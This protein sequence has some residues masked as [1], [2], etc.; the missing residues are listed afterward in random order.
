MLSNFYAQ[1]NLIPEKLNFRTSYSYDY[2]TTRA[3][4]FTPQYYLGTVQQTST[5]SLTKSD[6][7]FNNYVWDN[8]MTYTDQ[9]GDHRLTAMLGTSLRQ[10]RY[11]GLWG[12]AQNVPEGQDSWKYLSLGDKEGITLGDGGFRNR[13]LSYFARFNY[14]Y[15]DKYLLMVTLRE[16]GSSKY[17][18]PWGFFPSVGAAWVITNEDFMKDQCQKVAGGEISYGA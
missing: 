2:S 10:E 1:F 15:A 18:E 4:A 8:T 7:N 12:T 6:S 3:T 11:D 17:N 5:T 9:W 13:A 14:N 16:D